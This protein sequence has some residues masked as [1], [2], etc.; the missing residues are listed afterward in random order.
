[1]PVVVDSYI[2]F[3]TPK[4]LRIHVTDNYHQ[5]KWCFRTGINQRIDNYH[6]NVMYSDLQLEQIANKISEMEAN[7]KRFQFSVDFDT[8]RR[9][10]AN[11]ITALELVDSSA[12][13]DC[14]NATK[15]ITNEKERQR[16]NTVSKEKIKKNLQKV[17]QL[18]LAGSIASCIVVGSIAA[19]AS[20][21]AVF[22]R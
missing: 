7:K 9:D 5:E 18:Q 10:F 21:G 11:A 19:I 14:H 20:G 13:E 8:V 1:M 6:G 22:R 4:E 12:L 17:A 15:R 16:V 2:V 3:S